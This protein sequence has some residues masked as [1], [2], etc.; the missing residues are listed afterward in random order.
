MSDAHEQ[1]VPVLSRQPV[2]LWLRIRERLIEAALFFASDRSAKT[3]GA[4]LTIDGGL[5]GGYVR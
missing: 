1:Q 4:I 2:A 3:T 5:P